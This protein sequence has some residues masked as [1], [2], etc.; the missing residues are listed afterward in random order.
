MQYVWC[1]QREKLIGKGVSKDGTTVLVRV[2]G[3][4]FL[5]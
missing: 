1:G 3:G 4:I 2:L 5:K